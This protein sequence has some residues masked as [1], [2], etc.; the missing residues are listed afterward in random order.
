MV[1]EDNFMITTAGSLLSKQHQLRME[2]RR[3]MTYLALLQLPTLCLLFCL[4]VMWLRCANWLNGSGFCLGWR[5]FG[6]QGAQDQGLDFPK[7][8][9]RPSSNHFGCL[10][11]VRLECK[12]VEEEEWF[13]WYCSQRLD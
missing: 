1:G 5:L 7:D 9:M 2:M 13:I 8:S 10:F 4:S 11:N 3:L 6:S 12:R